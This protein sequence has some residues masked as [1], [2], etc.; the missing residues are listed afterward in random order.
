MNYSLYNFISQLV[1][2]NFKSYGEIGNI[3]KI[4]G[5][6]IWKKGAKLKKKKLN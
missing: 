1:L 5:R 6:S 3:K 4:L 2:E